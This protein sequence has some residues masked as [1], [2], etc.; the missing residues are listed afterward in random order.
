MFSS[1]RD[2]RRANQQAGFHFFDAGSLRFFN[3]KI[4]RQLY[5]GCYFIT[6]ERYSDN[7]ARLYTVRKA[8]IDGQIDTVGEFQQ[9]TSSRDAR[10]AI[11]KLIAN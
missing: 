11:K 9:Y 4:S 8:T 2:V 3:S 1:V 5:G 10:K 7:T 6:S